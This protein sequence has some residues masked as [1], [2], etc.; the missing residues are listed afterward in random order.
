MICNLR[1]EKYG[2]LKSN[3]NYEVTQNDGIK[4]SERKLDRQTAPGRYT[5][6]FVAEI[7]SHT[8]DIAELEKMLSENELKRIKEQKIEIKK[9]Q[10]LSE[11]FDPE[12]VQRARS[13]KFEK[14]L[15]EL[16]CRKEEIKENKKVKRS[17]GRPPRA[18]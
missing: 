5:G 8:D 15:Y 4:I 7:I 17:P 10:R 3:T 18:Q 14:Q 13:S 16:D 1:T 11:T 9:K 6:R 12:E 2:L